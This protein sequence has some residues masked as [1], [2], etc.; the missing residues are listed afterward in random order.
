MYGVTVTVI[1][2]ATFWAARSA[3]REDW[4]AV[5][6]SVTT[7][8]IAAGSALAGPRGMWLGDGVGFCT[9]LLGHGAVQAWPPPQSDR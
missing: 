4:M 9:V 1:V 6:L 8:L 7:M 5:G 2:L 3:A